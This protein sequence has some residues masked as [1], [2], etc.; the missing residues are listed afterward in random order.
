K[1]IR[2]ADELDD[3]LE[4]VGLRVG[5][6]VA[7]VSPYFVLPYSISNKR[8]MAQAEYGF[9][10][11]NPYGTA[12]ELLLRGKDVGAIVRFM[13]WGEKKSV[14]RRNRFIKFASVNFPNKPLRETVHDVRV[15]QYS[16]NS[17]VGGY[18]EW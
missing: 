17:L 8:G 14:Y 6:Q 2:S 10:T 9:H 11:H 15:R 18:G 12:I 16:G 13:K 1:A 3:L 5:D 4:Y 7:N